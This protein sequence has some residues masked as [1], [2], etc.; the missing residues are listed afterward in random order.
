[1]SGF[2]PFKYREQ[3]IKKIMATYKTPGVY[4]EEISKL[5]PSVAEVSTAIPA[6]IGCTEIGPGTDANGNVTPVVAR[7]N[8]LLDF[9]SLFGG[10]YASS[11]TVTTQAAN[12]ASSARQIQSVQRDAPSFDYLLYYSLSMYFKN[13]GGSCY[14]VSI[15]NYGAAPQKKQFEAGLAALAKEDEPTLILLTEAV[16]LAAADYYDLCQQALAQCDRLGDRFTILDV[17]NGPGKVQEFRDA[18]GTN[19]LSYGAAYYP[20]VL[21][22]M[23]YTTAKTG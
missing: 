4:V 3:E 17:P 15:G 18:I 14:I 7:I 13:G 21:T 19:N 12:G 16:N 10:P 1:L 20:Y 8:T 2:R 11:F 9:E 22:T 23:S 5:P 6:F